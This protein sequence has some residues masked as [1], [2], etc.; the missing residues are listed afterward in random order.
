VPADVPRAL[1]DLARV[2]GRLGLRWYVFGAQAVI[3]AGVP[4][5]TADID[6]T[7]EPPPG[8][9]RGL[10][11]A[12]KRARFAL[13][14]VG[15][16]DTF[17]ADARVIPA[18]H[19]VTRLPVDIVLAGPG[20]EMEMAER[21]RMRRVGGRE[22][23]FVETA[24]LLALKMLAGREKDLEDVRA[25]L[26]VSPADL[27][28]DTARRRIAELGALLD[29]SKMLETF[30]RMVRTASTTARARDASKRPKATRRT[31]TTIRKRR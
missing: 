22:I 13:R 4:R 16:I 24:D 28:V 29:D 26:R 12:L 6:V 23:P 11:A 18:V 3:A 1:A 5:L 14:D 20:L 9:A 2:F 31:P 10:L 21:A 19:L 7:V 8:G 15:D 25:L 17:I 27:D 30:V